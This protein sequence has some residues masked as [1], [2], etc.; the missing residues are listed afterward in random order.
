MGEPIL[1][2]FRRCP[3]AIRARLALAICKTS[4]AL[5][6]VHLA[7][8]PAAMLAS[9]PK[10]TVPV[11]V[12]EDGAVI[13]ES[14]RIMRWG[15]EQQDPHHW[16]ERNDIDLIA[17]NDAAFK[18]DLDRYKYSDRYNADPGLHRDS[19]MEFLRE[20]DSRLAAAGQLCG[21]KP[22]LTDAAILPFVR[23]FA[24]VDRKWFMGQPL[25]HLQAWLEG[26]L[27]SALFKA[28]MVRSEPWSPQER[29]ELH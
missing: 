10:G 25:K 24:A 15:L 23:Q 27:S 19:G 21:S 12:L 14:L 1:Y 4:Y 8:K 3:Y 18:H 7:R 9:S 16:L 6:E 22:G 13:D 28:V 29:T 2:S 11:L 5:R 26:H 20:L 17:R